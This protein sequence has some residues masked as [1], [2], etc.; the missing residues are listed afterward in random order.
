MLPAARK[1]A[2]RPDELPETIVRGLRADNPVA[3]GVY[4]LI[5][6]RDRRKRRGPLAVPPA[7]LRFRVHDDLDR[8]SFLATGRQ[9]VEDIRNA[10]AGV[11]ADIDSFPK[12]LDFGCGCGR[13]L[14][15][16][17]PWAGRIELHGTDIDE[18][19][20][21]WCRRSIDFASFTLNRESPPAPY[22][23]GT[24]DLVYAISVFTHLPEALHL[25]WL[26]ELERITAPGGYVLVTVRGAFY[27]GQL[28]AEERDELAVRGFVSRTERRAQGAFPS[29][30]QVAT[31][32]E[33]Y[34]R[35]R[36]SQHFEVVRYLS[37]ALDGCQDIVVLRKR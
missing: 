30:Y 28:S 1:L 4:A 18:D 2:R 3:R 16:L 12:V 24:F 9:C 31:H 35:D 7:A 21:S 11:G 37:A 27:V 8:E 34:V 25:R 32:T 26:G 20:V 36:C 10:L 15:W 19:A 5:D 22:E 13:T 23:L 6:W 29:W 14:L 33:E 17:R